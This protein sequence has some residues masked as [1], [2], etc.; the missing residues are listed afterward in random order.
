MSCQTCKNI[1]MEEAILMQ[2]R[3]IIMMNKAYIKSLETALETL[4]KIKSKKDKDRLDYT[5]I[6]V[7][8]I[9]IMKSSIE[10]WI[11]WCSIQKMHEIFD[12]KEELE[13]FVNTM[14]KIVVKWVQMDIDITNSCINKM[15][16]DS[17]KDAVKSKKRKKKKKSLETKTTM[18]VA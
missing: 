16:Q 15:E 11:K 10:G 6:L 2:K 4:K 1:S 17:I 14:E 7:S 3:K 8:M 9:S 18:Y 12:T 13:K 5:F